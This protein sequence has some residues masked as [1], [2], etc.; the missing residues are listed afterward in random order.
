MHVN[1]YLVQKVL[2]IREEKYNSSVH[3]TGYLVNSIP[4]NYRNEI[5]VVPNTFH[6]RLSCYC[7]LD[8][9]TMC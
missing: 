7:E 4:A 6:P 8:V 9:L 3:F 1:I 2:Q 5:I